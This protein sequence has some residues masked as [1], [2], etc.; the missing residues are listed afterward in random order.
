MID[1]AMVRYARMTLAERL[2]REDGEVNMVAI[3][4]ILLVVI[5]LAAV[6]RESLNALM[7]ELFEKIKNEAMKI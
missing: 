3:V 6:F 5:A 4:L 1:I 7:A 2:K